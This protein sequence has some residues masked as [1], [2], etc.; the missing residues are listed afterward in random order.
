MGN[1]CFM[2][3]VLQ[4][5]IHN[6]LLRSYFLSDMHNS[7]MCHL[8]SHDPPKS[9][10]GC[11]LDQLFIEV[12]L[13]FDRQTRRREFSWIPRDGIKFFTSRFFPEKSNP[14]LPI[15]SCTLYGD[16]AIDWQNMNN[17]TRMNFSSRLLMVSIN[18]VEGQTNNAVVSST[19]SL[20]G[21]YNPILNAPIVGMLQLPSILFSISQ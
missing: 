21:N 18:I 9:C 3:S 12:S 11:E 14:I 5:F 4:S 19:K 15:N 1:T 6:P 2:N 10:F 17:K 7:R 8:K 20:P 13:L 16:I